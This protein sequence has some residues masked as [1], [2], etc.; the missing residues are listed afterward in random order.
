[1]SGNGMP[2]AH[3]APGSVLLMN[4]YQWSD[5]SLTNGEP[6]NHDLVFDPISGCGY[7]P[8]Q[9]AMDQLDRLI[10]GLDR[11]RRDSNGV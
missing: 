11:W 6:T 1:M 3:A 7:A 2:A 8:C 9:R 4:A 5:E 10:R